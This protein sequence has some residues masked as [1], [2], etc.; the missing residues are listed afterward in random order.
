MIHYTHI[1]SRLV[2][3]VGEGVWLVW[4]ERTSWR[5]LQHDVAYLA[6][7]Q[8]QGIRS[9]CTCVS[10]CVNTM[11]QEYFNT[12]NSYLPVIGV[13][14]MQGRMHP[15]YRQVTI[16][17]VVDLCSSLAYFMMTQ[18]LPIASKLPLKTLWILARYT[19]T[20]IRCTHVL[21]TKFA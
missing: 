3:L 5:V 1:D 2:C 10:V 20:N 6:N 14:E 16:L 12:N 8:R 21:H 7:A 17:L 13:H 15:N 11:V 18:P 4:D 9:T 19:C